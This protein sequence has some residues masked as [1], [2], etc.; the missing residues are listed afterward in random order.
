MEA[1]VTLVTDGT[2]NLTIP[3][4]FLEGI[5]LYTDD[6][7]NQEKF[8]KLDLQRVIRESNIPGVPFCYCR[9]GPKWLIGHVP[10]AGTNIYCSYYQDASALSADSDHN[11]LT[12]LA[13]D[14]FIYGA[15]V[16]AADF[17][18]DERKDMFEQTFQQCLAD[19]QDMA[20]RDELENAS[21][22]MA[23]ATG[24]VDYGW[25]Y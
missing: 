11:W 22:G 15:L 16:R 17:F 10:P 5:A 13:P 9:V 18:L 8:S 12:D 7:I 24:Q 6:T 20:D 14:L 25:Y 19:L 21:V 23:C 2:P 4:D 1:L 3:G